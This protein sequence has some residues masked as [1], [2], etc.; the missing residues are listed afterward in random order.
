MTLENS[1][2]DTITR[3][4]E[5][6]TVEKLIEQQL[7][8]G[9]VNAL[10]NLFRSYG[11]VTKI[12]KDKVKSVMVPYL[13]SY[14]YSQHITKLDAVLV[15]V[16]QNSALENKQLLSNFKNLMITDDKVKQ[17]NVSD[18]YKHWMDYVAKN[19]DTNKLEVDYDDGVNYEYAEVTLE[20]E[21]SEERHWGSYE[22]A[23]LIFECE[24]DEE[25]NQSIRL[26]RWKDSKDK[27]WDIERHEVKDLKSLR[28][29][30]DFEL[31]L[32]KLN[33]NYTSLIIDVESDSDCVEVEAK[34]EPTFS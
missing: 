12:I 21:Y 3:K 29:L 17:L 18:L 20:V 19:I 10:E 24:K 16:L 28:H 22:Y 34:P 13:E 23:N 25:M 32:M 11:D 4:L 26:H 9:V 33:Q 27:G 31:L 30:N 7:E 14:D 6:G 1:I 2:K 15:D 8:K 5:D